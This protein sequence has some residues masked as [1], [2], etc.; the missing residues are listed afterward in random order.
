MSRAVDG[1][2]LCE[3]GV[4]HVGTKHAETPTGNSANLER[5]QGSDKWSLESS[6]NP[7]MKVGPA[8]H[9]MDARLDPIRCPSSNNQSANPKK[10]QEEKHEQ[11]WNS[12]CAAVSQSKH[13]PKEGSLCRAPEPH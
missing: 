7:Q 1:H 13:P 6:H 10:R 11:C 12:K 2:L 9:R 8:P 5:Q 4:L 3:V